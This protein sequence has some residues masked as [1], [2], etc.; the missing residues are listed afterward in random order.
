MRDKNGNIV[1]ISLYATNERIL[2]DI[3]FS[4]FAKGIYT[5]TP[6]QQAQ[7]TD[8]EYQFPYTGGDAVYRARALQFVIDGTLQYDDAS[9]CAAQNVAYRKPSTIEK[10]STLSAWLIPNPTEGVVTL[11]ISEKVQ[12]N[13]AL[14]LFDSMGKSIKKFTVISGTDSYSFDTETLATGIYYYSISIKGSELRGKLVVTK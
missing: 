6:T 12:E 7:I 11:H 14:R 4:T 2:N 10:E 9:A 3:Y 1:D 8:I 5:F 13:T